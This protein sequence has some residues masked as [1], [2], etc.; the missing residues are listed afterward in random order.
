MG[1]FVYRMMG[2]FGYASI[3][4]TGEFTFPM[5]LFSESDILW[6]K[7][8]SGSGEESI[9]HFVLTCEDNGFLQ[10]GET[11]DYS[12][13]S[14]KIFIVKINANGQFLWSREI[15]I[16]EHNLGNSAIELSD[17]YL[18]CGSLDY[19]SALI[20]LDKETGSTMKLLIMGE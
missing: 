16:G 5:I 12:N 17:G 1:F 2:R 3:T 11:Y 4:F 10:V 6:F 15:N 8:F 20:K 13:L 9:G 18:I 19:N 14:S 7:E